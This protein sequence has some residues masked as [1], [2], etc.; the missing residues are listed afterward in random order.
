M[1]LTVPLSYGTL[2]ANVRYTWVVKG[3][4]Q[5]TAST[6]VTQP[7]ASLPLFVIEGTP[8]AGADEV[9]VY[10]NSDPTNW[11]IGSFKSAQLSQDVNDLAKNLA[12]L[13]Q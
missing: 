2:L 11:N 4:K 6:G 8:P 12:T 5:P 9:F 1:R 7:D 10:D 13:A 3:V